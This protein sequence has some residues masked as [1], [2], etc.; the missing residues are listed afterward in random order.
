MCHRSVLASCWLSA[1]HRPVDKSKIRTTRSG[2]FIILLD[3]GR[4]WR[5]GMPRRISLNRRLPQSSS[6]ATSSVQRPHSPQPVRRRRRR[7]IRVSRGGE[8]AADVCARAMIALSRGRTRQLLRPILPLDDGRLIASM[9]GAMGEND[10]FGAKLISFFPE[11]LAKGLPS[12]QGVVLL[13]DA[14]D[15]APIGSVEVGELAAIRRPPPV[16]FRRTSWRARTLVG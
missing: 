13:F 8:V 1:V 2:V 9:P 10:L 5:R 12:R 15:G 6:R 11:N 4:P 7:E 3:G 14:A 16:R